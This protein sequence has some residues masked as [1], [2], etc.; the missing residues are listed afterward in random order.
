MTIVLSVEAREDLRD[1]IL[2]YAPQ[3]PGLG[4]YFLD[5]LTVE[6]EG[7]RYH[8]GIHRRVH[9]YYRCLTKR[10]PYAIYYEVRDQQIMVDAILEAVRKLY[11][12]A[13]RVDFG[14]NQAVK[15]SA[16]VRGDTGRVSR[17]RVW[18]KAPPPLRAKAEKAGC[19]RCSSVTAHTGDAPSS[20]PRHPAFSAF[21]R[22]R[23]ITG[24][25]LNCRRHPQSILQRLRKKGTERP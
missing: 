24:Q 13:W 3:S 12:C 1:G 23:I 18:P 10:F 11:A 5:T 9:G 14:L 7:L 6:I 20:T 22:W 17:R 21:V 19:L 8:A 4:E 25:P 2:F 15:R 16:C